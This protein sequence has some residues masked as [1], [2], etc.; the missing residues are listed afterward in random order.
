MKSYAQFYPKLFNRLQQEPPFASREEA[1][2]WLRD[3]W[4]AIHIE[5]GASKRRIAIMKS[6]RIC[7]EQGWRDIEEDVCYLESAETPPI[8]L[9]LHRDGSIVLQQMFTAR[10]EILFAKPGKKVAVTSV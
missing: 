1:V 3:A 9:F 7:K 5:A 10:S 2:A 6:A 4:C 8:R